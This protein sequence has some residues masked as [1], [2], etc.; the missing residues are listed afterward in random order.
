MGPTFGRVPLSYITVKQQWFLPVFMF[1]L[2][3]SAQ[4]PVLPSLEGCPSVT[5]IFTWWEE[6]P[7]TSNW[8]IF[9]Y[10]WMLSSLF[11]S[12]WTTVGHPFL[13]FLSDFLEDSVKTCLGFQGE[14]M[15]ESLWFQ[16][17]PA[18]GHL[19]IYCRATSNLYPSCVL[20][21]LR[22]PYSATASSGSAG[23]ERG[24]R[25]VAAHAVTPVPPPLGKKL[26]Q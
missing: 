12:P 23:G 9:T 20:C 17:P 7:G 19:V 1:R 25:W 15:L 4:L 8:V 16:R 10:C 21:P 5:S 13:M 2:L 6:S 26:L 14:V 22:I 18:F 3:S 24:V 11:W